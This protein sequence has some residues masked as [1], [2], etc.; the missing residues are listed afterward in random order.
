MSDFVMNYEVVIRLGFFFGVFSL[1]AL[2]EVIWPRRQ[3]K[4]RRWRRW[5]SNL[6]IVVLDTL[7][8]RLLFPVTGV[9]LAL[10]I[11]DLGWGLFNVLNWPQVVE[12]VLAVIFLDMVIYW[13]HVVFHRVPFLWRLHR[14]HHA[15]T[16][17]DV[18]LGARFHP[19]EIVLSMM[20][21][22]VFIVALGVSP[23]AVI[24][25]EVLLNG[26]AMFNHG[27]FK[28]PPSVDRWLRKFLVTPDFHRV[29]HSV[30]A[31]ETHSNFGFNL[32]VWDYLFKTYIAQ[33]KEP[34]DQ[35][36]IGL[37]EFLN[38]RYLKL[39]WLLAIPFIKSRN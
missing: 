37:P 23:V 30:F 1:V 7:V 18:T 5:P 29:H 28:L 17:Y 13:Q 22:I 34:H 32:S 24:A 4:T 20:I 9:L 39:H 26:T 27:N 6:G 10:R 11:Q 16:E 19:I 8:V 38:P 14:M 31:R 12:V 35:M 36:E 33:P 21:K 3:L 25:F 2:A 15:D